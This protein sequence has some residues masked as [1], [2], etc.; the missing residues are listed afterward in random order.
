VV[1]SA[2]RAGVSV[3]GWS[4]GGEWRHGH[5]AAIG[6]TWSAPAK[7]IHLAAAAAWLGGLLWLLTIDRTTRDDRF[8]R[9]ASRVSRV[10]LISVIAVA[11][12]GVLQALLFAPSIRELIESRYAPCSAPRSS[13]FLCS[14]HS[15]LA[16]DSV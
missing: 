12:S 7:A 16:T 6:A 15:A 4:A 10:A 1:V 9:E 14:S 11:L 8:M 2:R 5:S 3:G 13:D